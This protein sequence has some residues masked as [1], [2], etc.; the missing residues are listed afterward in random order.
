MCAAT[1]MAQ[2]DEDVNQQADRVD[3][4]LERARRHQNRDSSSFLAKEAY[5]LVKGTQYHG[6]FCL[7]AVQLAENAQ[8]DRRPLD[9]LKYYIEA[10]DRSRQLRDVKLINRI[11]LGLGGLYMR[12]QV[13]KSAIDVYQRA[14][15]QEPNNPTILAAIAEVWLA[16]GQVDSCLR[17]YAPILDAD[18]RRG[19]YASEVKFYQKLIDTYAALGQTNMALKYYLRIEEIL[20]KRGT[21]SER[22]LLYNNLGK[23]FLANSDYVKAL[24]YLKKAELQCEYVDCI[25]AD[26]MKINLAVCLFNTGQTRESINYLLAGIAILEKK[27]DYSSLAH[28]EEMLTGVYFN[29]NDLYNAQI[30][31]RLARGYAE[32]GRDY[33]ALARGYQRAADIY[34]ELYAYEDAIEF[35][36]LFLSLTDSLRF[37][38]RIKLERQGELKS[39][40]E[41]SERETKS[42]LY[43][44]EIRNLTLRETELEKQRLAADNRNLALEARQKEEALFQLDERR[45][46]TEAELRVAALEALKAQQD[47][48][49]AAQANEASRRQKEDAAKLHLQEIEAK[50]Q[51]AMASK[52]RQ[53]L[54]LL[55]RDK[56]ISALTLKENDTFRK[57]ATLGASLLLVIL[58]LL[59]A[60][61]VYSKR[62][63]RRLNTQNKA[64]ELQKSQIEA[65]RQRS[66]RLLLN[67]LPV[68]VAD[69]LKQY[70]NATP[71]IYEKV[72]V[73]FT[74]FESFT[75][76]TAHASPE[77]VL[78]ELNTC[79][80]AFDQICEQYGL[81]K[82]K[83]I[84]DAYM[85]AAGVPQA[86][87][88]SAVH[89]TQA[90]LE[91]LAFLEN[92]RKND[93]Q[94]LLYKMR[95][96]I[97]T[98]QV[99]AG[100][101]GKNKFAY[102]IWGDTVN[103]AARMEE[104]GE[105]GK[106]NISEA[107]AKALHGAYA[108]T[109]RG[110]LKVHNKG[111]MV[112]Y[113]VEKP[114]DS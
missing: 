104:F 51:E 86:D 57:Y 13:Y 103:T 113:F 48:R 22:A 30:H 106:V 46:L 60:G 110:S 73:L 28:A 53:E 3:M 23:L 80:Q 72:S 41:R 107:T 19:D 76:I 109:N 112:M 62:A 105:S 45:K 29:S 25:A 7:A 8:K 10:S 17:Y 71:R 83:T 24:A 21:P 96:G 58:A 43:S 59:T 35:Y 15:E 102:D 85:A 38:D 9:A 81:E 114:S 108:L 11:N 42:L 89:A 66:E 87:E 91:M 1:A 44:Q 65:E 33:D 111:D 84:G 52:Q 82:I 20:E 74:D 77:L 40:L 12:E 49:I 18:I 27:K 26:A 70:G 36:K 34:F 32:R 98:G 68:E 63:N 47:L 6:A 90:G 16:E 88:K 101:V 54:E 67:I 92:R 93:K 69:E 55:Q 100:V 50:N 39:Q 14:L 31:N 95:V 64:I 94:A 56:E 61:W 97:H 78:T 37:Q 79:F 99:V 75:R 5:D 4:L 2:Q